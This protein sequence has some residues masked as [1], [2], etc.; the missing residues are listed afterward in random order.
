MYRPILDLYLNHIKNMTIEYPNVCYI[1][2]MS[3][4]TIFIYNVN[5]VCNIQSVNDRYEWMSRVTKLSLNRVG[6]YIVFCQMIIPGSYQ[7]VQQRFRRSTPC[8]EPVLYDTA[9][10]EVGLHLV[11]LQRF[12]S[13]ENGC[14]LALDQY[15]RL[16]M[17]RL[18][19]QYFIYFIWQ[20]LFKLYFLG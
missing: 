10:K 20:L 6:I 12:R 5:T 13:G 18:E 11:S 1:C 9:V 14:H 16:K 17:I 19:R 2:F 4:L 3:L 15:C 8:Y 7:G